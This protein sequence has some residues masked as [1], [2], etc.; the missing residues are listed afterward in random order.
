MTKTV[1]SERTVLGDDH[2]IQGDGAGFTLG[3]I[4]YFLHNIDWKFI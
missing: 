1:K 4:I 3:Y 2:S